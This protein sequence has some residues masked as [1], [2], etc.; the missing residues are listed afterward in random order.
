MGSEF[1]MT[2]YE[3]NIEPGNN[4]KWKDRLSGSRLD[5]I[6]RIFSEEPELARKYCRG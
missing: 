1:V 4:E 3:N 2:A 6:N 5:D